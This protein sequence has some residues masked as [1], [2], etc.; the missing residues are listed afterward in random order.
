MSR[1][2]TFI[3]LF[4][5]SYFI[6]RY[7]MKLVKEMLSQKN[8]GKDNQF[9]TMNYGN[10]EDDYR[11]ILGITS[12]DNPADIRKKYR[13]LLAACRTCHDYPTGVFVKNLPT[14]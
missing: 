10:T 7:V 13:E 2:I 1:L 4:I 9:N 5:I 8:Q 11:Q 14:R 6:F 12:V 3:F